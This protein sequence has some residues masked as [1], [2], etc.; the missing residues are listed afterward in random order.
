MKNEKKQQQQKM[1][2]PTSPKDT[3]LKK[4]CPRNSVHVYC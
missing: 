4:R 2:R 1:R 3:P